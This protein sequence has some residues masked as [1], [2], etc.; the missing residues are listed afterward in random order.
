M[1]SDERRARRAVPARWV[2]A[3]EAGAGAALLLAAALTGVFFVHRPGEN[4]LDAFAF[5]ALPASSGSR[6]FQVIAEI[7]SARVVVAAAVVAV[8]A[9]LW[10][11]RRRA[12]ACV[13]GPLAGLFVTERVAKP[14]AGR[15]V[16]PFGAHS[17][18]SG[19]VTAATAVVTVAVLIA[20]RALRAPAAVIA[21]GVVALV[22]TAVI[23]LRWHFAT[24]C[25]GGA[26]V[27]AGAVLVTDGAL[28][29]LHPA[30]N[31]TARRRRH[32]AAGSSSSRTASSDP[33]SASY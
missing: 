32:S 26:F 10:R 11:D 33:Y 24:D 27:G 5:G 29:L 13:L 4:R 16:Y 18:P 9:T 30:R 28:H 3:V 25:L 12:A 22:S 14:L 31:R 19:T 15:N 7:G 8:V 21:L 2:S 17:Y 23:A 6:A 1:A 20:P